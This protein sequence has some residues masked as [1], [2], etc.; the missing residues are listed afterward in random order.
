[1][2]QGPLLQLRVSRH[3]VKRGPLAVHGTSAMGLVLGAKAVESPSMEAAISAT[4]MLHAT[5]ATAGWAALLSHAIHL[6]SQLHCKVW[7]AQA[8]PRL[9]TRQPRLH[10]KHAR[11]EFLHPRANNATRQPAVV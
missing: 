6:P 10:Q 9:S 5:A 3:A 8:S 2:L 4:Q 1:M 7:S 11:Y